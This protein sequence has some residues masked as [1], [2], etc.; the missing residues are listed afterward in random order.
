MPPRVVSGV[1]KRIGA[2]TDTKTSE[3]LDKLP[4]RKS[5][6]H[7][8]QLAGVVNKGRRD[9]EVGMRGVKD[10]IRPRLVPVLFAL[11]APRY[12]SNSPSINP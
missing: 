1:S 5:I 6:G 9:G 2:L 7:S 10:R 3:R 12:N 11:I 4:E 8:R